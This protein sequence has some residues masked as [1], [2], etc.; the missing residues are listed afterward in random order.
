MDYREKQ[1]L[2]WQSVLCPN[3]KIS[4]IWRGIKNGII[5]RN[6]FKGEVRDGRDGRV[7]NR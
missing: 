6:E 3:W 1:C 7:L 2:G 4:F 5:M